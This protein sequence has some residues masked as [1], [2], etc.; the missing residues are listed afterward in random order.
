MAHVI[1]QM[2]HVTAESPQPRVQ[3]MKMQVVD[4][5]MTQLPW[6]PPSGDPARHIMEVLLQSLS[7]QIILL[8]EVKKKFLEKILVRTVGCHCIPF[9]ITERRITLLV[10]AYH[11]GMRSTVSNFYPGMGVFERKHKNSEFLRIFLIA[12]EYEAAQFPT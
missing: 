9:K 3:M 10:K 6:I 12:Q 1:M 5:H 4:Q 8:E 11:E 7:C 2:A